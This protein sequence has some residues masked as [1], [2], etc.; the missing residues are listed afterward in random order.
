MTYRT[1]MVRALVVA[2]AAAVG[3]S[4]IACDAGP[5][6]ESA[7][8]PTPWTAPR[9]PWGHPDLQGLWSNATTTPLERPAALK[10]KAVLSDEEF[11]QTDAAVASSRNTDQA[12]RTGD[13]GT[14]NE[15][16]WERGNLLK[17][18]ALIVD[19]ADGRVPPLTP[20]GKRRTEAYAQSRQGRGPSDSWEDRNLH[21]R[22]I[23]YHG[24]PPLPT[25]YNNN[26]QIAQTPDFVVIRSEMLSETRL[27]PLD[28]RPHL[29]PGVRQW[30]GDPRGRWEGDT[31]VVESTNFTST[32]G[33]LYELGTVA[34]LQGTGETIRIVERFTRVDQDTIDYRFTVEDPS[35]FTQPW[36]GAIPMT[37][38]EGPIYE[39]ACHE[40]NYAMEGMLKG[41]RVEEQAARPRAKK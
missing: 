25:G 20:E 1:W 2:A 16:W 34:H 8:Q 41:A 33:G 19:P 14:Y 29:R 11:E 7:A 37:T 15:F 10:D 26:Y 32:A 3:S 23:L 9:T 17:Q 31:L 6:P 30:M 28:G 40:G 13:P 5:A 39:Y 4:T 36:T 38:F 35:M 21:E 18:T 12:P 24:V 22:C 27:I